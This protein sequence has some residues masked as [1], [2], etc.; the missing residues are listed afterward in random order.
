MSAALPGD[1]LRPHVKAF[2]S[3]ALARELA[4]AGHRGFCGATLRELHG[5]V[6]AGLGDDLLLANET[7]DEAH[8]REVVASGG[9]ITIA[10][11]SE[12]TIEVAARAGVREVLIDVNVG[13]PRCGCRPENAG[14]LADRA[15]Q[16][17]LEVRGVMGY[18]GHLMTADLTSKAELVAAS[19]ELLQQAHAEVGGDIVSG[20]GTGTYAINRWCTEIQAGSYLLMDTHYGA[21][22]VP[23]EQALHLLTTVVSVDRAGGWA[24]A[25]G[26]LKA[27]GMDHGDPS[28]DD[29]KVWFCSDEHTTFGPADGAP[30]PHVGDRVRIVPAHVDPTVA[31]HEQLHVVSGDEVV[32][33]W[34]VDLR[35]W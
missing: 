11:D 9:R 35:G 14:R 17:G 29:A 4:T 34:P 22:E 6:D 32:D 31:Y 19:M 26:G 21:S 15:R 13:M 10:V 24:V 3:T 7:V 1:R 20:G 27:L 8:L 12:E 5:L 30:L 23:F 16:A 2:K 28:I 33:V 25:D 18:E